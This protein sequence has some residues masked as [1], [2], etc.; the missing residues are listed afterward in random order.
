M[1]RE[2][3]EKECQEQATTIFE[4]EGR[5]RKLIDDANQWKLKFEKYVTYEMTAPF[6]LLSSFQFRSSFAADCMYDWL[7]S[8]HRFK[9]EVLLMFFEQ[10]FSRNFVETQRSCHYWTENLYKV[11]QSYAPSTVHLRYV[12]T[13]EMT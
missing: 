5:I 7:T 1:I 6:Y 11:I 13:I 9:Q 2:L 8:A 4:L 10:R 12:Y 3:K